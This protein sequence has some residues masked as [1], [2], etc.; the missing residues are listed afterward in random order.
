MPD[1]SITTKKGLDAESNCVFKQQDL[2]IR[3]VQS[4]EFG[5]A[6]LDEMSLSENSMAVSY[7]ENLIY[8]LTGRLRLI[9]FSFNATHLNRVA[10]HN[11]EVPN[12]PENAS[13]GSAIIASQDGLYVFLFSPYGVWRIDCR[14]VLSSI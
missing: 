7:Q 6:S 12:L 13:S 9:A 1:V 2:S 14:G 11:I 10:A 3:E 8:F 5:A 4:F